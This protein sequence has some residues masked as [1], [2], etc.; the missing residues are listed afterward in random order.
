[1]KLG[2]Y[3][4]IESDNEGSEKEVGY[5]KLSY[6]VEPLSTSA[7]SKTKNKEDVNITWS[8]YFIYFRML[9]QVELFDKVLLPQ[10]NKLQADIKA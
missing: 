6:D 9:L 8:L 10:S 7:A 1:M 3:I 5:N 2:P 4:K